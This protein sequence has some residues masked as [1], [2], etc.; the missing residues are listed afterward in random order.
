MN[1]ENYRLYHGDCLEVMD[2]L[3]E[4]GVVV[5]AIICDPPYGTT[6]CKWDSIIPFEDM[7]A[8][9]KKL[10]KPNG[11]IALFGCEPFSSQLRCSNIKNYKYD[12]I[13][14]KEQ[15]IGQ[16][17]AK[18]QP[19]R[20]TENISIFYEKRCLYNPQMREG[21]PYT[22]IR[23]QKG[24][25]S[26]IYSKQVDLVATINNGGRYPLTTI[27]FNRE[28]SSKKRFHPTQKPIGLLEYLIK[29]YTNENELVLDFTMGSGST[30]VA[31]MNTNRRFIGIELDENY[32]NIAV[33]RIEN[34]EEVEDE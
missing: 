13:W 28:L 25:N 6:R 24:K 18:R 26:G 30:G 3:I 12:W 31:C 4:E 15:G 8:R 21:E 5:D 2:R 32:F 9:I 33:N 1:K 7:W 11:V 19:L 16:L 29:T 10:I 22:H 14:V 17:N 23:S 20:N 27:R 34:N